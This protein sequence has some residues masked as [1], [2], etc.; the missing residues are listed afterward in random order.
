MGYTHYATIDYDDPHWPEVFGRTALDA[1][2]ILEEL[3]RRGVVGPRVLSG[4]VVDDE[5]HVDEGLIY[6]SGYETLIIEPRFLSGYQPELL[7]RTHCA[8]I[9]CKTNREPY[10]LAVMAILYRLWNHAVMACTMNPGW[11]C[12]AIA[13]DG[14]WDG[15]R[16]EGTRN[17]DGTDWWP[18]WLDAR[19]L[20]DELFEPK[21]AMALQTSPLGDDCVPIPSSIQARSNA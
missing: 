16:H 4:T 15:S 6:L 11:T 21:I 18:E 20:C 3:E 13:S 19:A 12:V 17:H 10:D 1:K 7:W 14:G 5:W 8:W 2:V 9:C